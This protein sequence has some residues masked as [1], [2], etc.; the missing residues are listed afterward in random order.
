MY[1]NNHRSI[2]LQ[3]IMDPN[4]PT[5]HKRKSKTITVKD[6]MTTIPDYQGNPLFTKITEVGNNILELQVTSTNY[7]TALKW[8]TNYAHHISQ[9][10]SSSTKHKVFTT[11]VDLSFDE[12][13]L[14]AW[15]HHQYLT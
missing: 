2:T 4:Q 7:K 10:I 11:E 8:A 3:G 6:W 15:E 12:N 9:N 5:I 13:N 14:E 1:V